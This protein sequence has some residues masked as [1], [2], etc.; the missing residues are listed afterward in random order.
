MSVLHIAEEKHST[1]DVPFI[2]KPSSQVME[3]VEPKLKGP[4]G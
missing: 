2:L 1:L 3:Q 4:L